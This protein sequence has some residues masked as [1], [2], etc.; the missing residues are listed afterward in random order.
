MTAPFG[1]G[2]ELA[3]EAVRHSLESSCDAR[4]FDPF[5]R[6]PKGAGRHLVKAYL[7]LLRY[8]PDLW[9]LV[10][11]RTGETPLRGPLQNILCQGLWLVLGSIVEQWLQE[12]SP[13]AVVATHPFAAALVD[14]WLMLRRETGEHENE[15]QERFPFFVVTTDF[16]PHPFWCYPT[17]T[18]YCVATP[19][20]AHRL[21]QMGIPADRIRVT[22]IP[23]REQFADPPDREAARSRIGLVAPAGP[24]TPAGAVDH[25]PLVLVMGGGLGVGR[26]R[27][28]LER[29]LGVEM[30]LHLVVFAGRN[31][32]LY[33]ELQYFVAESLR[34]SPH[35]VEI[36]QFTQNMVDWMAAADLLIT[37]PGGLTLAEGLAVGVPMVLIDPVPGQEEENAEYLVAAG[38]ALAATRS[39]LPAVV[40]ELLNQQGT[41]LR[42]RRAARNLARPDAARRVAKLVAAAAGCEL[43]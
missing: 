30:P 6:L 43:P 21:L 37:K 35:R 14:A 28:I 5:A 25:P 17:V 10:Y 13:R 32:K 42:L 27:E 33:R 16:A 19:A 3:A 29:L 41:R 7:D 34:S 20:F 40:K 24:A 18:C 22:G 15:N 9:R 23:V 8:T 11:T 38:A 36:L 26:Y 31:Q 39:S 4:I 2:H 1:A 12:N